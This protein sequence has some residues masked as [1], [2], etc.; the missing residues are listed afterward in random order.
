VRALALSL[1][2]PLFFCASPSYASMGS[3]DRNILSSSSTS[4]EYVRKKKPP[5]GSTARKQ[6]QKGKTFVKSRD[7]KY[8]RSER[9]GSSDSHGSSRAI[10]EARKYLGKKPKG[11]MRSLWCAQFMNYIEKKMGR[12]GTGSNLARSYASSKHYKRVSKPRPGDIAVLARGKRG[13]HVGYF[14]GWA[15]NGKAVLISGNSSGGKVAEG[16][17]S[18]KRIIAWVRP[19]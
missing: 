1:I 16:R 19:T 5:S 2:L 13:G 6:P 9:A 10:K 11:M 7:K 8:T 18:T 14:T 12:P 15:P 4:V 17:Y 3:V